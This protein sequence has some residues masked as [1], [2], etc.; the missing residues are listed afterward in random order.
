MLSLLEVFNQAK[1]DHHSKLLKHKNVKAYM[2]Y[3]FKILRVNNS[4]E[5]KII[6][7]TKGGDFYREVTKHEYHTFQ[8]LGWK[9]AIYVLYLSNCRTK[10]SRLES[11]IKDALVNNE[12]VKLIRKLKASRE[13]ILK[14]FN[15]VKIKLN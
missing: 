4:D 6:D 13:Q 5:I 1:D 14:N 9:T 7:M 2:C 10:L 3:G 11:R 12:S 15:R 8:S